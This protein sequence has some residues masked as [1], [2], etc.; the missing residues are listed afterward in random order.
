MGE[1]VIPAV[2]EMAK[3]L[4]LDGPFETNPATGEKIEA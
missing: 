1:E 3:E 2:K 4:G